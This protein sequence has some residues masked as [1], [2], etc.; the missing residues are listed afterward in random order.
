MASQPMSRSQ[1]VSSDRAQI[2]SRL[3]SLLTPP[4]STSLAPAYIAASAASQLVTTDHDSQ[5]YSWFTEDGIAPSGESVLVSPASLNLVN[6]FLDQLLYNFLCVARS[7]ALGALRSAVLEVLK[8]TL[9]REAIEGADQELNEYLGDKDEED[10]LELEHEQAS[11]TDWDIERVWKQTRLRCMVYSSL[12]DV[13]EDD[14]ELYLEQEQINSPSGDLP[15]AQSGMIPPPVAV[16]LTSIL[17]FIGE[18]TLIV[19]GQAAYQR[20]RPKRRPEGEGL[21]SPHDIADRVV[22][23]ELDT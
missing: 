14:E 6:S 19:A 21:T 3:P 4:T 8:P 13:E 1:S 17:E 22:V 11:G 18:Q 23:L 2:H 7:T 5:A 15:N 20:S 9:A 12:G 10:L 16:F